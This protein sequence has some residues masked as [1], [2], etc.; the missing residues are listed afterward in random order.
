VATNGGRQMAGAVYEVTTPLPH[1][2]QPPY[3]P[4]LTNLYPQLR[5]ALWKVKSR[6]DSFLLLPFHFPLS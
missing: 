5:D 1:P 6:K 3:P 4:L 2:P